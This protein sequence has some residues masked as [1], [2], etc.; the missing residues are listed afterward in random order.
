V[1]KSSE[2]LIRKRDFIQVAQAFSKAKNTF[3]KQP[4]LFGHL[5]WSSDTCQW[6]DDINSLHEKKHFDII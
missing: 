6:K 1:I 4:S 2:I 3:I 5:K